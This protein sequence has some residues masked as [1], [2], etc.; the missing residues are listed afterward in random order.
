[1]NNLRNAGAD[2]RKVLGNLSTILD[3]AA[4]RGRKID[5]P[6]CWRRGFPDVPVDPA[7]PAS[8]T[9]QR[10]RIAARGA[11]APKYEDNETTIAP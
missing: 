8:T 10:Q 5:P 7:D 3:K 11:G 6:C 1:M 9:C 4:R 2:L